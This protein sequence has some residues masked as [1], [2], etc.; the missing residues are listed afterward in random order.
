V[1]IIVKVCCW[2]K[3]QVLMTIVAISCFRLARSDVMSSWVGCGAT[4]S[5]VAVLVSIVLVSEA[6][7]VARRDVIVVVICTTA[8][9]MVCFSDSISVQRDM[10]SLA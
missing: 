3:V 9:A 5:R 2:N 10:S 6:R 8:V 7:G 1:F 4:A